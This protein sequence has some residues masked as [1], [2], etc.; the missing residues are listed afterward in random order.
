[1]PIRVRRKRGEGRALGKGREEWLAAWRQSLRA[2]GMVEVRARLRRCGRRGRRG[3]RSVRAR[4]QGRPCRPLAACDSRRQRGQ[5][6]ERRGSGGA[7]RG[8]GGGGGGGGNHF[9]RPVTLKP[10]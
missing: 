6:S 9:T 4:F 2:P 8:R 5:N 7:A 1:M 10:P 3:A